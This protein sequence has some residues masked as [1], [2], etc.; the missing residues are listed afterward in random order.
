MVAPTELG[1]SDDS[2]QAMGWQRTGFVWTAC[3]PCIQNASVA[4]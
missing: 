1:V 3:A 2:E 4:M